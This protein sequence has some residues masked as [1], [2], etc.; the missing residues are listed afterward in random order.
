MPAAFA[1]SAMS[2]E[3]GSDHLEPRRH[4]TGQPEP[5]Q[6]VVLES[7]VVHTNRAD[8]LAQTDGASTIGGTDGLES[9]KPTLEAETGWSKVDVPAGTL[10][11]IKP[12]F[13]MP[14]NGQLALSLVQLLRL[15]DGQNIEI[16]VGEQSYK[17]KRADYLARLSDLLPDV[18]MQHGIS[19]FVGQIQ[20]FGNQAFNIARTTIN[21]QL[22]LNYVVKT[23]GTDFFEI[24]ASRKRKKAQSAQLESTRQ[25]ILGL[26]AKTYYELKRAYWARAIALQGMRETQLELDITQGRLDEGVGIKLDVLQSQSNLEGQRYGQ[27]DAERTVATQAHK[28]AQLLD[29]DFDTNLVPDQLETYIV[30][31]IPDD[32]PVGRLVA[33]AI[34]NNPDL[35]YLDEL[36][37]AGVA[38][39]RAKISEYMPT[40]NLVSSFG[41]V[42][43]EYES[44]GRQYFAGFTMTLDWLNNLGTEKPIEIYQLKAIRKGLRYSYNLKRSQLREAVYNDYVGLQSSLSQITVARKRVTLAQEAFYFAIGRLKEGVG[45]QLQVQNALTDLA[46][47]RGDLLDA[48]IDYN[49][50]QVNLI[51]SLGLASPET[52]THGITVDQLEPLPSPATAKGAARP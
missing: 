31:L 7:G 50:T 52:L 44:L 1:E 32:I 28:L 36:Q 24:Q 30:P 42:G 22:S 10:D 34:A 12:V 33:T 39:L 2:A 29:I 35:L 45:T 19:R 49:Q 38:D 51:Q 14:D 25:T 15:A 17:E 37:A 27:V 18:G 11:S 4:A 9:T 8:T 3:T 46:E 47:A 5:L 23:G 48:F 43:P 41:A 21:P 20:V 16:K 40:V 6:P 26:T 13:A